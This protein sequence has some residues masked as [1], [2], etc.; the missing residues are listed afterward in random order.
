MKRRKFIFT[1][2]TVRLAREDVLLLAANIT[3]AVVVFIGV[4]LIWVLGM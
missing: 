4:Y 1:G 3:V 2:A